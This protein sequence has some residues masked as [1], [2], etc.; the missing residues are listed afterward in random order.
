MAGGLKVVSIQA[1]TTP[2]EPIIEL[3]HKMGHPSF[4]LLKQMYPHMLK[5]I[6]IEFLTYDA[7]QLGKFKRNIYPANNNR[8]KR[9]FQILHCDV[10]GPSPHIDLLGHQYFLICTADHSRFT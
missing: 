2:V 10:W 6:K 5:D 9:P 8:T 4:H 7:C 3:R 1:S